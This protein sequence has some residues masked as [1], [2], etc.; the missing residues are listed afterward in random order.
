MLTG[1][2]SIEAT[3]S[4]MA[5]APPVRPIGIIVIDLINGE[6][7]VIPEKMMGMAKET[8]LFLGMMIILVILTV[9]T[10]TTTEAIR[11]EGGELHH[12]ILGEIITMTDEAGEMEEE[13]GVEDGRW[14][15]LLERM[16]IVGMERVLV[17]MIVAGTPL[18][19][20]M[21]ENEISTD[22]MLVHHRH[23]CHKE[24]VEGHE[25]K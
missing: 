10:N 21:S 6:A 19:E 5:P 4:A 9:E 13:D 12:L 11:T 2:T 16:T 14:A 25:E 20:G 15:L 22:V 8:D 3:T 23:L 1:E 24:E 7:T 17:A 18:V